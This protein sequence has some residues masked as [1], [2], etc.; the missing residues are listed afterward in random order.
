M[1]SEEKQRD[2]LFWRRVRWEFARRN[3]E[4]IADW[5][6][7]QRRRI[8]DKKSWAQYCRE[9]P[10]PPNVI[11][12]DMSF[13]QSSW[14]RDIIEKHGLA[15]IFMG[16]MPDPNKAFEALHNT[17]RGWPSASFT[18]PARRPLGRR[19]STSMPPAA[20]PP[21]RTVPECVLS[22]RRGSQA[23]IGIAR[24]LQL[25]GFKRLS[26][27]RLLFSNSSIIALAKSS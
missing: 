20:D 11:V 4:Y 23:A 10:S 12:S 25:E 13:E 9:N 24:V 15:D 19:S 6:E 21:C 7:A 27:A 17:G 18:T 8:E 26:G 3:P 2:K 16:W 14:E 5:E 1:S 22:S